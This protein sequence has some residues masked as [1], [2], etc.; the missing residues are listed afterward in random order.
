MALITLL[1]SLACGLDLGFDLGSTGL[2]GCKSTN[3]LGQIR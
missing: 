1:D 3:A 2:Q